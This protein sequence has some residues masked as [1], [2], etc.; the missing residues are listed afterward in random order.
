[1]TIM[2]TTGQIHP[3][4]AAR[5]PVPRGLKTTGPVV[6]S[7]GFRPFFLGAGLWAVLAMLLWILSL[8]TGLPV[9]GTYGAVH[10]HAHEM[11][12][13]FGPAVLAGF[14]LTA[15]PNWTG[16]LPVSGK[17]LMGL[18]G[19]WLLGRLA[20]LQPD[21][22]HV[23]VAIAIESLFLPVLLLIC[24]REIVAGR[25]WKDLKVLFGVALLASANLVFHHAVLTDGDPAMASRAA[26][27]AY[28]L[29][30]CI[31]GGR[32]IPSFTRNW[33]NR[34]GETRF[35][36]PMNGYD[37]ACL[38]LAALALASWIA[39]PEHPLTVVVAGAAALSHAVRLW[40]W[41]G[42]TVRSEPL[43]AILHV[44]YAF[45]AFGFLAIACAAAG[46]LNPYSAL[47]VVTVGAIGL[48][49]L[50][51]MGRATRGHTGRDLAASR[52]PCLAY[53]CL[54]GAAVLRPLAEI[55]PEF[56]QEILSVSA[57]LWMASFGL[58]LVEYAPMLTRV[59]RT[60]LAG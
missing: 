14:L 48:M 5:K 51:V 38:A 30:I 59:R 49:M 32:I 50:A 11:L 16:R 45:V 39:L 41:R 40:R 58:F 25:K 37:V 12:F 46:H 7:Y 22:V 10:W 6:F 17:P 57:L 15:V 3:F 20:F 43:L 9:G 31:I 8:T 33:L 47:H 23:D 26:A 34:A 27:G 44:A 53:A 2:K 24:V 36:T 4:A 54:I 28:L 29:L 42:W 21:I 1:V 13:G 19:L 60:P 18:A 52:T 56:Y 55:A 35:P